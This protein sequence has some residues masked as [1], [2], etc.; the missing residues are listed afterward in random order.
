MTGNG[1]AAQGEGTWWQ[2]PSG[3][4][5]LVSGGAPTLHLAAGA[6]CAFHENQVSFDVIGASGAGAL[7]GL[8]YAVPK[9]RDRAG[10]LRCTVHLNVDDLVYARVPSNYKVFQKRGPLTEYF[11]RMGKRLTPFQIPSDLSYYDSLERWCNDCVDL[12]FAAATPTTLNYFSKSVCQRMPGF[13]D[14][15]VDWAALPDYPKEFFVNA[16]DLETQ[17][18][19]LFDKTNLNSESFFAALAMPWLYEPATVNGRRYTEGASHD[20]SGL[21]ALWQRGNLDLDAIIAI[22]TVTPDLWN[23][24]S[25]IYD[26]LQIT[27]MDPLV[28]LAQ[29]MLALYGRIEFARNAGRQ[30]GPPLPKLYVLKFPLPQ[31]EIPRMLEWS[32]SNAL[33]LWSIGHDAADEF[34]RLL[35]STT[36]ND[37][38]FLERNFRYYRQYRNVPRVAEF[39]ELFDELLAEDEPAAPT[40]PASRRRRRS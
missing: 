33:T 38:E 22:E 35:F 4:G 2:R 7:P 34:C 20:P 6:L 9:S 11:W 12:L 31:W 37:Q 14:D 3:L 26:A 24:P 17:D 23:D 8:L 40:K 15:V 28:T 32:Y 29:R 18:L 39:L 36:D 16:F 10:A 21:E 19:I 1:G 27:I 13:L 30:P 5:V 25:N